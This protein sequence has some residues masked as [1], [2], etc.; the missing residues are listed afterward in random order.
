MA[1]R[2][3]TGAAPAA[4]DLLVHGDDE[5]HEPAR[6]R[7]RRLA[8][9]LVLLVAVVLAGVALAREDAPAPQGSS[10][11]PA[12]DV[13][14]LSLDGVFERAQSG[15]A[16]VELH[17]QLRNDGSVPVRLLSAGTAG[18]WRLEVP[19]GTTLAPGASTVLRLTSSPTCSVLAEM[20]SSGR[21][22]LVEAAVGSRRRLAV[23]DLP[24]AAADA[25]R[26]AR[27]RER[28]LECAAG[29]AGAASVVARDAGAPV[30]QP[31]Q[32]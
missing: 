21:S 31:G 29:R 26:L 16:S 12:D 23:V 2:T 7:R 17:V 25:P 9:A 1:D 28:H 6:R 27:L 18:G 20:R 13:L 24:R 4:A 8:V 3:S 19:G 30:D 22:L 10:E 5:R 15:S 11:G 32:R 14:R